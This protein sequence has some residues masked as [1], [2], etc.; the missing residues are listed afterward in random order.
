MYLN[1]WIHNKM[2]YHVACIGKVAHGG[3]FKAKKWPFTTSHLECH[4]LHSDTPKLKLPG[5]RQVL[6]TKISHPTEA[7]KRKFRDAARGAASR[8]FGAL[9]ERLFCTLRATTL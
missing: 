7:G 8:M 5:D 2:S 4:G 3:E 1:S 9:S 6:R